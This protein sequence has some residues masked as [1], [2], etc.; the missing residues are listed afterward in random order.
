[1]NVILSS[2]SELLAFSDRTKYWI[3]RKLWGFLILGRELEKLLPHSEQK[4]RPQNQSSVYKQKFCSF[5]S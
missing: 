3:S 5:Y 4:K 1:M 2:A